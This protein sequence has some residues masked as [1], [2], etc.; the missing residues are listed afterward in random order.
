MIPWQSSTFPHFCMHWAGPSC[1]SFWQLAFWVV[2]QLVF[3]IPKRW[4]PAAK[5]NSSLLFLFAGFAWFLLPGST[6]TRN[7]FR[8]NSMLTFC[9]W[10][11][12]SPEASTMVLEENSSFYDMVFAD[13]ISR[14]TESSTLYLENNIGYISAIYLFILV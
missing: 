4:S 8:L 3:G 12:Q 2:Y 13:T 11:T 6:I 1:H 10:L 7:I 14:L 9:L 5:H